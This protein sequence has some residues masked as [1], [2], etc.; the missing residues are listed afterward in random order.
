MRIDGRA[1]AL[2]LSLMILCGWAPVEA[3][4]NSQARLDALAR[5]PDW[6]GVWQA[7]DS[8]LTLEPPAALAAEPR[9]QAPYNPEWSAAYAQTRAEL[10]NLRDT[11]ARDCAAGV[12]RLMGSPHRFIA[13]VTPEE[14]LLQFATR[15]V[16]HIWTDGRGHPAADELRPTP[17]GDSIG[18]WESE[19]LVIDT[20]A[21]QGNRWLDPTGATLSD[22]ARIFERMSMPDRNHLRD[23]ITIIDP[24]ALTRAWSFT[25]SYRRAPTKDLS[26]Q[27]CEEP[28]GEGP[29]GTP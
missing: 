12:P 7:Q 9:D 20:V 2:L 11:E 5:L 1:P 13:L 25:R 17:W 6:S 8:T 22:Q 4:P 3:Q 24:V 28:P 21:I 27:H 29:R 15:E 18:H 14:T 26:E 10:P 19:T 16:R 23:E